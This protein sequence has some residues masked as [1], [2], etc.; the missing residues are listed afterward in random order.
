M[1]YDTYPLTLYVSSIRILERPKGS[2]YV[3]C[4]D[5]STEQFVQA[6]LGEKMN[7]Q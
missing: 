3:F 2:S 1:L 5:I 6:V 4:Y 7:Q